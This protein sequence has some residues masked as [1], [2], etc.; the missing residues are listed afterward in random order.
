M[1]GTVVGTGDL[2]GSKNGPSPCPLGTSILGI[3]RITHRIEMTP[4]YNDDRD[5]DKLLQKA[6]HD[7]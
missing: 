2:G 7:L 1:S 3:F 6:F 4:R 5:G